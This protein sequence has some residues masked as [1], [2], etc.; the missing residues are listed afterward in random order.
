MGRKKLKDKLEMV[1]GAVPPQVAALLRKMA[2]GEGRTLSAIVRRALEQSPA[3]K[4]EMR[5]NGK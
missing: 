1:Q 3:V 4:T 5:R 2:A